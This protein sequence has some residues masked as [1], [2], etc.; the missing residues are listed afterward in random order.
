MNELYD[1][2][3]QAKAALEAAKRSGNGVSGMSTRLSNLLYN[4]VDEIMDALKNA[5][6]NAKK[7]ASLERDVES[8]QTALDEADAQ[9]AAAK[10]KT[11]TAVPGK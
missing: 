2:V 8:L 6:S 10:A 1:K 4:H 9:M 3:Y 7:I 5:E 11:K